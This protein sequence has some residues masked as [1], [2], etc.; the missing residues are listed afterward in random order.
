MF[1][2]KYKK[3]MDSVTPSTDAINKTLVS[4]NEEKNAQRFNPRRTIQVAIACCLSL[5]LICTGTFTVLKLSKINNSKIDPKPDINTNG[6][7]H[8]NAYDDIMKLFADM[9]KNNY[10]D[11]I[12]G[13][14]DGIVVEDFEVEEDVLYDEG[15]NM[16]RPGSS[17]INKGD[18]S[19]TNNQVVGVQEADIIKT[20]GE[21]IYFCDENA[22][23]LFIVRTN[24]GE[25]Q[26]VSEIVL[27]GKHVHE[28]ILINNKLAVISSNQRKTSTTTCTYY[29]IT[30]RA[31]PRMLTEM[32]Q[33]GDYHDSRAIGNNVYIITNYY[34]SDVKDIEICIPECNGKMLE[35]QEIL[36]PEKVTFPQYTIITVYDASLC[37]EK[38]DSTLSIIDAA[39]TIYCGKENVYLFREVANEY[40][41]N[42][43]YVAQKTNV[44]RITLSKNVLE[45]TATGC[46]D[47]TVN[48]QFSI[49]EADGYLRIATHLQYNQ[50]IINGDIASFSNEQYNKVFCLD[51]NLQ[52]IGESD[53]L[54]VDESI[55]SVRYIGDVAY[56]VT[57]RQTDPLYAIDLSDPTNPK[58]L[59]EL[60]IDG[61]STYMHPYG[62]GKLL[63]IGFDADPETGITRG[64]KLTMFDI[65][66]NTD[67]NEISTY[68]V[69]WDN[70]YSYSDALYNHKATLIDANK[71]VIALPINTEV[72]TVDEYTGESE[73]VYKREFV[74]F[75]FS[76]NV[77]SEKGSI[78]YDE[79]SF[80]GKYNTPD[81]EKDIERFYNDES[82]SIYIDNFGYIVSS[83][84]IISISL[85]T[86]GIVNELEF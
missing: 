86:L 13:V 32:T 82:R 14:T 30:D 70:G 39:H 78:V 63:G 52:I 38:F 24:N 66:D 8:A 16:E 17:S 49:D 60:K 44:Y 57:F 74:F 58:T 34:V 56:V 67:I 46:V 79:F 75:E 42:T 76:N 81:A 59:S 12:A 85:E 10:Y 41:E 71:G 29:D 43:S 28:I 27:S 15:P 65:S 77:L 69:L 36:I 1:D 4:M 22:K 5:A 33:D 48:N 64:L 84:G 9:Q 72:F 23:K 6:L 37:I 51:K 53:K 45:H 19:D 18:Y 2:K 40:R 61:F 47:G 35:P 50:T 11:S 20:D 55:K 21:Y 83:E 80:S 25:L 7:M 31:T 68:V 54:G 73:N 3:V 26:K 62:D